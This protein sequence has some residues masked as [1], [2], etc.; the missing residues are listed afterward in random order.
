[1]KITPNPIPSAETLAVGT[2]VHVNNYY[3]EILDVVR[4]WTI[5]REGQPVVIPLRSPLYLIQLDLSRVR[6]WYG[7]EQIAHYDIVKNRG[8]I[9]LFRDE[10]RVLD[11]NR[12]VV[13]ELH[14][15]RQVAHYLKDR[16]PE[17]CFTGN[18]L[19]GLTLDS[20][21]FQ[22]RLED[23]G[24]TETWPDVL[25]AEPRQG[26]HGLFLHLRRRD[27]PLTRPDGQPASASARHRLRINERLRERGYQVSVCRQFTDAHA[28]IT[29]YLGLGA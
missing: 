8:L 12:E 6:H 27:D 28:A 9:K 21:H 18:P 3:G 5:E 16:H 25:I 1:M 29:T 17:V 13:P 22:K 14:L 4:T 11:L 24:S 20:P 7:Q 19:A 2:Y 15:Q 26:Y 23:I 10:F